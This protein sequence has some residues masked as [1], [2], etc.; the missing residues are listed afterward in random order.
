MEALKITDEGHKNKITYALG[1]VPEQEKILRSVQWEALKAPYPNVCKCSYA[2]LPI[3]VKLFFAETREPAMT[4][5]IK[6]SGIENYGIKNSG[7][8]NISTLRHTKRV[9][10]FTRAYG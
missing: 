2:R 10:R 5:G 4:C 9:K 3:I 7:I 8:E 1:R 6:N